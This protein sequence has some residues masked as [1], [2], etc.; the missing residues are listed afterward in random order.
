[1]SLTCHLSQGGLPYIITYVLPCSA[2]GKVEG[3]RVGHRE[4]VEEGVRLGGEKS[5][6][7]FWRLRKSYPEKGQRRQIKKITESHLIAEY[8]WL[9]DTVNWE[10]RSSMSHVPRHL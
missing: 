2:H 7:A 4:E 9:Q 3:R 6:G 1:M 5:R 8:F 10:S